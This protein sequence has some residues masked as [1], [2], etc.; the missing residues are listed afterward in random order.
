MKE[1][2]KLEFEQWKR[3]IEARAAQYGPK[4]EP[5]VALLGLLGALVLVLV[6]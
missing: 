3:E 1:E 5:A 2:S 4:I 6:K